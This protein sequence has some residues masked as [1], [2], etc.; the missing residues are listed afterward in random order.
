MPPGKIPTASSLAETA[1]QSSLRLYAVA[2][3]LPRAVYYNPEEV[4]LP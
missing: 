1:V 2:L 4:S 3:P